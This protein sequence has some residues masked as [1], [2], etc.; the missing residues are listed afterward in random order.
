MFFLLIGKEIKKIPSLVL[1]IN[2]N[3]AVLEYLV[4]KN[5]VSLLSLCDE[6]ITLLKN[7]TYRF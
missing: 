1:D 6:I 7:K 2:G 5:T 3:A 4:L